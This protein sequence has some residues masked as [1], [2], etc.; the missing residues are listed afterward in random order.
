M[1]LNFGDVDPIV[2]YP[3]RVNQVFLCLMDNAIQA[4][5][6]QGQIEIS[7][8]RDGEELCVRIRDSGVGI[9]EEN[10]DMIFQPGFTTKGGWALAPAWG[11]R[12]VIRSFTTT[13]EGL[14]WR[15]VSEKAR[16]SRRSCPTG[17][18]VSARHDAWLL[19]YSTSARDSRDLAPR[20]P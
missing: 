17:S 18:P 14:R 19:L 6:D 15:A 9:P 10:L 4:I 5:E 20:F 8:W 13:T 7:T 3:G 11:Y 2:C 12:S 16:R 1:V